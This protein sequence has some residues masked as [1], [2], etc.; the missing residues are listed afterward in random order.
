V[1]G[2]CGLRGGDPDDA[3]GAAFVGILGENHTAYLQF[4]QSGFDLLCVWADC[5]ATTED[6]R[7]KERTGSTLIK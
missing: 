4:R 1:S 2:A 5:K 7:F 3:G 6:E